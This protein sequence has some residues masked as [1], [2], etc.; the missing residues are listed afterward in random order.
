MAGGRLG[1]L[2]ERGRRK[3]VHPA[4]VDGRWA[5]S[6]KVVRAALIA[7]FIATPFV[8]VGGQP[9]LLL[10]VG[11]RRFWVFGR[12][13][14]AQDAPLSFLVVSGLGFLLI[15]TA[16]IFGRAWCG[17]ACPQTVWLEGVIRPIERFVEGSAVERRRRD[18]APWDARKVARFVSKHTLFAVVAVVVAAWAVAFFVPLRELG[19]LGRGEAADA[20]LTAQLVAATAALVY[21][22][23]AWFRE[24]VCLVLCPYGRLQGAL[25]DGHTL[26]VG[27]DARRGEPRGKAGAA[28][29]GDCVDCRRCVAVCPMGVDVREGPQME[30]VACASCI[31]ACDE[32]MVK[33][34]RPRG[35]VRFASEA[36]LAGGETRFL[37]PRTLGYALAGLVGLL[38]VGLFVHR[39]EPFEANVFRA[40]GLPYALD[41]TTLRA[42]V[43]VHV[44]NKQSGPS[45][46]TLESAAR[47]D[48]V[49]VR[50][51][52][53]ELA[54]APFEGRTVPVLIAV[55]LPAWNPGMRVTLRVHDGLSSRERCLSIEVLGPRRAGG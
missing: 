55:P 8:R 16:A 3:K 6:Q 18:A 29:A 44:V 27:Y 34:G 36:S 20:P 1:V 31:D 13:F 49:E 5:R 2:D 38:V 7:L 45:T 30:C 4:D 21:W 28:R 14:N 17:W 25:Q 46:I 33:L 37:R 10:E 15:A 41:G 19:A 26:L 22:D 32:V 53:P 54:L 48:G 23:F 40:G 52:T 47:D 12:S 24:Q 50:L 51:P 42:Q 43:S 9:L 35:L 11:A 39:Y